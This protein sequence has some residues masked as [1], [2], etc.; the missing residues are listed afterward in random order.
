TVA[1]SASGP[2]WFARAENWLDDR[3]K[4]ATADS[5]D[6]PRDLRL[7]KGRLS[8]WVALCDLA[9]IW[10]LGEVTRAL[11]HFADRTID[12]ALRSALLPELA[13][14]KVP[15]HGPDDLYDTAGVTILAMGKLGA[16]ELNYSSDIDLIALF[17]SNRFDRAD[18]AEA[19][20]AFVRA[21][22][23]MCTILSDVTADG[24]VFRTDLRLRPDAAVTPV[25]VAMDVAETYYESVGRTWERAAFIKARACAGDIAGGKAFLDRLIPFVWRRHLDF[26]AIQDAHDMRKAIKA[27]KGLHGDR[28]LGRDLKLGRGGI[29]EIEFF[30]QTRQ[31]I[32]GGRDPQLRDPGTVNALHSLARRNW[33]GTDVAETLAADYT[34]HRTLEH[35]LQMVADAQTHLLPRTDEGFERIAC[36]MGEVDANVLRQD[37]RARVDRVAAFAEQFFSPGE[38]GKPDGDTDD[39]A[40]VKGWAR[41]PALRSPRAVEI[42]ERLKPDLLHRLGKAAKPEEAL[43]AFDGFLSGLPAGVQIF[44]LFEANPQLRALIVDIAATAPPLARYLS[45]N[46]G[47]LD[48]VIGG[49]FFTPWPSVPVLVQDLDNV[50]DAAADYERQLDAVRRWAKEWHFRV[51]VHHLRGLTDAETAGRQYAGL[52]EAVLAALYTRVTA[53]LAEKHGPPPGRG[54]MVLAMGSLGA[55]WLN[56]HS[57]LDLIIIYDADGDD[58]SEGPR[59]L[60]A[61]PYYARLTQALVT[62]ISAPTAEGKLY[63]VDTRLRPSGRQGPVATSLSS[64]RRYHAEEAW[65]W[66]HLALTRAR[67][68]AGEAGVQQDVAVARAEILTAPRHRAKVLADLADMRARLAQ[69]PDGSGPLE[70][71]RGPGH[72]QDIALFAQAA[73]LL[74]GDPSARSPD[75]QLA[76][77][78]SYVADYDHDTL[79]RMDRLCRAV[80]SA[81]RLV[82]DGTISEETLGQGGTMMVLRAT[83]AASL[84]ELAQ[85]LQEQ[86]ADCAR[87]ISS[88]L[89]R[90]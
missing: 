87:I 75:D 39:P 59:P 82:V 80:M 19:R 49:D 1:S 46:S 32:A 60:A 23:R 62:A 74:A 33:I 35:R 47:V 11:S 66:E 13:R 24:Y 28:L 45:R 69:Q 54:A 50:L 15:G 48:A 25:C 81:G 21:T 2:S 65:T 58:Y 6:P 73:T 41:Y 14:G 12:C 89:A 57:D 63:D 34:S 83:G 27:H 53:S 67:P 8:L 71:K 56:A 78:R 16:H 72:A 68:V 64:F 84:A 43:I 4:G 10:S 44:S 90:G 61:R 9:G 55:G 18:V 37:L 77:A 79:S 42:F 5:S 26:A 86:A 88:A 22:R 20:A 30:T 29:R 85:Q 31:L 38:P 17:D 36:F 3:G 76:K 7:L 51:G 70:T 40:I 52:A